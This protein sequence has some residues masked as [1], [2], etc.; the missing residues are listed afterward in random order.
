MKMPSKTKTAL[1]ALFILGPVAVVVLAGPNNRI[2]DHGSARAVSVSKSIGRAGVVNHAAKL[3]AGE[4][5]PWQNEKCYWWGQ[6]A[7]I[8]DENIRL[9]N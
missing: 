5:K 9:H 4:E 2:D 7:I 3:L 1:A 8:N 6:C